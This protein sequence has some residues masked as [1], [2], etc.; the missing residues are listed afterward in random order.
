MKKKT[1][2]CLLTSLMMSLV[3]LQFSSCGKD[4]PDPDSGKTVGPDAKVDDPEGTIS[5]SMRNSNSGD[6][7]LDGFHIKNENFE[8]AYFVSLGPVNGLGNVSYIPLKGWAERVAVVPGN[9]YVAYSGSSFYR[10]Y[11]VSEIGGTSGGVIGAEIKYQKPFKG[12]D[13]TIELDEKSLSFSGEGGEQSL[14]FNNTKMIQFSCESNQPWC[15]VY[16]SSTTD[17]SFLSNAITIKVDPTVST[18]ADK[19]TVTLTTA[20]GKSK[21]IQVSRA[22]ATPML[23]VA[24][25]SFNIDYTEQYISTELYTNCYEDM[26]VVNNNDW[27]EVEIT[28]ASAKMREKASKIKFIDGQRVTERK[29][30]VAAKSYNIRISVSENGNEERTGKILLKTKDNKLSQDI[31][32]VQNG[33]ETIVELSNSVKGVS[34]LEQQVRMAITTNCL[35][36]LV[37]SNSNKWVEAEI[38]KTGSSLVLSVSE[39]TEEYARSGKIVVRTKDKRKSVELTLIQ[40]GSNGFCPN[41]KHPHALDLGLGVKFACCNVGASAPWEDGQY[42]AWGETGAKDNY[43]QSTYK[44]YKDGEYSNIGSDIAGTNYDVAHVLWKGT[45]KMP[46]RDQLSKLTSCSRKWTKFKDKNGMKFTGTNGVAIF[47][48]AAGYCSDGKVY[49]AGSCGYYWSSTQDPNGSIGAYYLDYGSNAG[50]SNYYRYYGHTVR[51][52]TE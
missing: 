26:T 36:E 21:T 17:Y 52:V 11:V 19:A 35:D 31:T 4:D 42:F 37:V 14:V 10:I 7:W 43:S 24:K 32:V 28:D 12:S 27:M 1:M 3:V 25:N 48:P 2:F 15:H 38:D 46:T 16:K 40:E 13:E 50:V 47:L 5:L 39:S 41:D 29:E 22:G 33:K 34:Q 8:G 9:G 30:Q 23:S 49:Y 45:W 20:Y 44:F 6:T 18:D 51:P